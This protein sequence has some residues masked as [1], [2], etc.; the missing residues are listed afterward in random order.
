MIHYLGSSSCKY[1]NPS[2]PTNQFFQS[3]YRIGVLHVAE[4][5]L[6]EILAIFRRRK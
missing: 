3:Y 1:D 2:L 6:F 4:L 5:L